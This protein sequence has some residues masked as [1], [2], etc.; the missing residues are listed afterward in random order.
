MYRIKSLHCTVECRERVCVCDWLDDQLFI[1]PYVHQDGRYFTV[2][3]SFFS[4]DGRAGQNVNPQPRFA[5]VHAFITR[6]Y[7]TEQKQ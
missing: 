2:D 7:T 1:R 5:A 6:K 3:F 4:V